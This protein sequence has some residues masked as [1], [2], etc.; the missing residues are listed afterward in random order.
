MSGLETASQDSMDSHHILARITH[1]E[2]LSNEDVHTL[3][4][5]LSLSQIIQVYLDC[6]QHHR[7][8]HD[9]ARKAIYEKRCHQLIDVLI[10]Q[11]KQQ[12]SNFDEICSSH[13]DLA[14]P[15][16]QAFLANPVHLAKVIDHPEWFD[17]QHPQFV[18]KVEKGLLASL[19][20]DPSKEHSLIS[21]SDFCQKSLG[22]E[23]WYGWLE[24]LSIHLKPA[25]FFHLLAKRDPSQ[26]SSIQ[27]LNQHTRDTDTLWQAFFLQLSQEQLNDKLFQFLYIADRKQSNTLIRTCYA[28]AVIQKIP[29]KE[30]LT[31]LILKLLDPRLPSQGTL[32]IE[33]II[34]ELNDQK[35]LS[36]DCLVLLIE[37]LN[38]LGCLTLESKQTLNKAIQ[39]LSQQFISHAKVV[40]PKSS[41]DAF[42][43]FQL[44]VELDSLKLIVG[45]KPYLPY[46]TSW[47]SGKNLHLQH[48]I[49]TLDFN[50][51]G[52]DLLD[53]WLMQGC[54]DWKRLSQ[55]ILSIYE[56]DSPKSYNL[57]GSLTSRLGLKSAKKLKEAFS[58]VD[59]QSR[60]YQQY[61]SAA[62]VAKQVE[63]GQVS[64]RLPTNYWHKNI[65]AVVE[66]LDDKYL[67]TLFR[68]LPY[69]VLDQFWQQPKVK[70]ISAIMLLQALQTNDMKATTSRNW[71]AWQNEKLLGEVLNTTVTLAAHTP[72]SVECLIQLN[73]LILGYG[74]NKSD[75]NDLLNNWLTAC[76]QAISQPEGI[77]PHLWKE[78]EQTLATTLP[79]LIK[80]GKLSQDI[81][82]SESFTKIAAAL[83]QQQNSAFV[84][85]NLAMR[86]PT[87]QF[88]NAIK[89]DPVFLHQLRLTLAN[90]PLSLKQPDNRHFLF[91]LLPKTEQFDFVNAQL[92]NPEWVI[93]NFSLSCYLSQY[94][95][96]S[97]LY[98]QI[99]KAPDPKAYVD[100]LIHKPYQEGLGK[101]NHAQKEQVFHI[102]QDRAHLAR[103]LQSKAPPDNKRR[104]MTD[105]L[106]YHL[107]CHQLD[108]FISQLQPDLTCL[109]L[110]LNDTDLKALKDKVYSDPNWYHLIQKWLINPTPPIKI[111]ANSLLYQ[112]V[113]DSFCQA[114]FHYVPNISLIN[115]LNPS[116]AWAAHQAVWKWQQYAD[117]VHTLFSG[118]SHTTPPKI[119][120]LNSR[121]AYQLDWLTQLVF[122]IINTYQNQSNLAIKKIIAETEL[123]KQII[124]PLIQTE[125][126]S[127]SELSNLFIKSQT[128]LSVLVRD[129]LKPLASKL[130]LHVTQMEKVL[131]DI[132]TQCKQEAVILPPKTLSL[133][134]HLPPFK[135]QSSG[136]IQFEGEVDETGFKLDIDEIPYTF[137]LEKQWQTDWHN[138]IAE[139]LN[140]LSKEPDFIPWFYQFV[141]PSLNDSEKVNHFFQQL[142]LTQ[143]FDLYRQT[144]MDLRH[145]RQAMPQWKACQSETSISNIM[146]KLYH[147]SPEQL[148]RW[149]NFALQNHCRLLSD[150]FQFLA[151]SK[152][153]GL[154]LT[155]LNGLLLPSHIASDCQM[156]WWG[157]EWEILIQTSET[158]QQRM[159][160]QI[161]HAVL[162]HNTTDTLPQLCQ[163]LAETDD[164]MTEIWVRLY[165]QYQKDRIKLGLL[166]AHTPTHVVNVLLQHAN[167]PYTP[168]M[169]AFIDNLKTNLSPFNKPTL[170]QSWIK[171][172]WPLHA[173]LEG[174]ENSKNPQLTRCL[175]LYCLTLKDFS[176]LEGIS[177]RDALVK[178]TDT[179]VLSAF[180]QA[181]SANELTD[182]EWQQVSEVGA[183]ALIMEAHQFGKLSD[184]TFQRLTTK[185]KPDHAVLIH[186]L[187]MLQMNRANANHRLRQWYQ[188]Y[189]EIT[190]SSIDK[191]LGNHRTAAW[192]NLIDALAPSAPDEALMRRLPKNDPQLYFAICERAYLIKDANHPFISWLCEQ[193][194]EKMPDLVMKHPN[195]V[196]VAMALAQDKRFNPQLIDLNQLASSILLAQSSNPASQKVL[197]EALLKQIHHADGQLIATMAN[198][199]AET[200]LKTLASQTKSYSQLSQLLKQAGP[201]LKDAPDIQ[202]KF[203][204]AY[205]HAAL[206]NT[207]QEMTGLFK[208]LRAWILRLWHQWW[209]GNSPYIHPDSN[210]PNPSDAPIK[211]V[212]QSTPFNDIPAPF[213]QF[214]SSAPKA[215]ID[216]PI[217][218][219]PKLK[220]DSNKG[221]K[222]HAHMI[223]D[224]VPA[225]EKSSPI[226]VSSASKYSPILFFGSEDPLPSSPTSSKQHSL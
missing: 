198:H 12:E 167:I 132:D 22:L 43:A 68:I 65:A 2:P 216:S 129:Y 166:I 64:A 58:N 73:K 93:Q 169:S 195:I 189:P 101:L 124:H 66:S 220:N 176:L 100:L 118:T 182:N 45:E 172:Q 187:L 138:Q 170:F 112:I 219:W 35:M 71:W 81:T 146:A 136:N 99:Q 37:K 20:N 104:L 186:R 40:W 178:Q 7:L 226:S 161:E 174:I 168:F 175:S 77:K 130:P 62:V 190:L 119:N 27:F 31:E 74:E 201:F 18:E 88:D 222:L 113:K 109:L 4:H 6:R 105:L 134:H 28:K 103:L 147:A 126:P 111:Q 110:L 133:F 34:S 128:Q 208:G 50:K 196:Q 115:Q 131:T 15:V 214:L 145:L 55:I 5:H 69:P 29:S 25:D 181:I 135:V 215:I 83:M 48:L 98:T 144:K 10:E 120:F 117:R 122:P 137:L 44:L 202:S 84:V 19:K 163:F 91:E 79:E 17:W 127:Y 217:A 41:N 57:I 75:L 165:T 149:A 63:S 159:F 183:L 89:Q 184:E 49:D 24:R 86:Y 139:Q 39:L 200:T 32:W 90:W 107:S 94:V 87:I 152:N 153:A 223:E 206:E 204:L 42:L 80:Y 158:T 114:Q 67:F 212:V 33:S 194:S 179:H 205:Q 108:E 59:T 46:L 61:F 171:H 30:A 23:N 36:E 192:L 203:E 193:G 26:K 52:G 95:D 156:G 140:L 96:S 54:S 199:D 211:A 92:G 13:P 3:C 157:K 121:W 191:L 97:F 102:I 207:I 197:F 160:Q 209:V 72:Q 180:C 51:Q 154:N 9:E 125:E 143:L 225:N 78:L 14:N 224:Y 16:I 150:L 162:Q 38:L 123:F 141:L 82:T 142:S 47:Y 173:C 155:Q 76:E 116:D 148:T 21:Y 188:F 177:I 210:H 56:L 53:Q 185:T 11:V 70:K 218:T 8:I 151:K 213:N 221:A 164:D 1:V 60:I 85:V 106:N